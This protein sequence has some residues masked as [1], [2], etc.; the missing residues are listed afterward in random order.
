MYCHHGR[1][2]GVHA[3]EHHQLHMEH[4]LHVERDASRATPSA[5]RSFWPW[6]LV[7]D[8]PLYMC[9]EDIDNIVAEAGGTAGIAHHDHMTHSHQPSFHMFNKLR[10][11]PAT[12]A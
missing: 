5:S 8:V 11:P 4:L 12:L 2:G 3:V 1:F 7:W 6:A 9:Y 10:F